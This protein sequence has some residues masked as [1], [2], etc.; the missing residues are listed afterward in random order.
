MKNV[1]IF[2]A[3]SFFV[4]KM[5][6]SLILIGVPAIL[7]IVFI[8]TYNTL[9]T[10][11]NSAENAFATIDVMLKKRYDLIPN[12]VA[13]VK[14]YANH[15]YQTFSKIAEL[16]AKQYAQFSVEDKAELDKELTRAGRVFILMGENYPQLK[17][18]DNF[19]QLQRTLNEIEEQLAAARRAYNAAITGY[20]N[21]VDVFPSNLVAGMFG[22]KRKPVFEIPQEEK[23]SADIQSMLNK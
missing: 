22:F 17:A 23:L 18:S 4:A 10:K 12:L 9:I 14:E 15:E 16:R 1:F 19:M 6:M 7:I 21:R 3:S 20:N 11:R 5:N 13:V 8:S 2:V